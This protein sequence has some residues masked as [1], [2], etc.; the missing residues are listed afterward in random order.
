MAIATKNKHR[1]SANHKKRQGLHQRR[2]DHFMKT[3]WPYIPLVL[4]VA[5]GLVINGVWNSQGKGSVLG[6]ATDINTS[7]LY[8]DTNI[9]RNDNG[10]GSLNLNSQLDSAAQAK[11]ND[12]VAQNY[13]SHDTP[14]GQTPWT[15]IT[16]AGY[17]Y[18]TAGENL[19]YGF[20]NSNDT[21]TGWM[22]SPEHRANILNTTYQ[23]V[24]F[25]VANSNN[26]VNTGPETIVVAMYASPVP[27]TPAPAPVAAAKPPVSQ[28][29]PTV[30]KSSSSSAL[31]A[32]SPPTPTASPATSTSTTPAKTTQ[33]TAVATTTRATPAT[34]NTKLSIQAEPPSKDV[35][36]IQLITGG[37][38]PW[39]LFAV[40]TIASLGVAIFIIRHLRR[41]QKVLVKSE[42]YVA[43]HVAL[44][45]FVLTIVMAG[46]V[47]IQSGGVIR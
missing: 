41:F 18:Q 5:I 31:V 19:A 42:H 27:S 7:D 37:A 35:A 22:N 47:L 39:S 23:D 15:F 6:L 1:S 30:A 46:F 44:D 10:L 43:H 9:Q 32:S 13:W 25:G 14:E 24:G 3:Y 16:A 17:N 4:I 29:P 8:T 38:A 33:P 40:S 28:S 11:A 20:D 34:T 36:R 45:S 21:I 26:F 2:S 12:M